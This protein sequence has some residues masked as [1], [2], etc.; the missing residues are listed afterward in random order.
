[1][2]TFHWIALGCVAAAGALATAGLDGAA[3]VTLLLGTG[4]EI[5]GAMLTGKQGNDAER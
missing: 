2:K 1:M 5:I 4:V 3:G